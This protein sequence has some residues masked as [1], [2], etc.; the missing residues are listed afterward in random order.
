M[1]AYLTVLGVERTWQSEQRA[2]AGDEAIGKR[3]GEANHLRA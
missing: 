1:S 3:K 2:A